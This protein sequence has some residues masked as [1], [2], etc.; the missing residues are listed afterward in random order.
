MG[1]GSKIMCLDTITIQL[2]DHI[3]HPH[4][5]EYL[6]T[7]T[8]PEAVQMTKTFFWSFL[9]VQFLWNSPKSENSDTKIHFSCWIHS[10]EIIPLD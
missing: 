3:I 2:P 7:E 10:G 1:N 6:W 4:T 5:A 9:S 8:V